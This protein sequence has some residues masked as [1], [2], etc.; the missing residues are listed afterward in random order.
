MPGYIPIWR[1]TFV[2]LGAADVAPFT[3]SLASDQSVLYS[4]KAVRR[5]DEATLTVRVNDIVADLLS[6]DMLALENPFTGYSPVIDG[7]TVSGNGVTEACISY[8]RPLIM[9]EVSP[10]YKDGLPVHCIL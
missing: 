7:V 10:E 1:D 4:G 8:L 9:G 2:D 5:P 3:V 6:R